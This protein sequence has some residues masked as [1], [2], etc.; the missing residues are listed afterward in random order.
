V[1]GRRIYAAASGECLVRD[2]AA[3]DEAERSRIEHDFYAGVRL[4]V[5]PDHEEVR[6][7]IPAK[8]RSDEA[9]FA[10][11][12]IGDTAAP[13]E[14]FRTVVEAEF[15]ERPGWSIRDDTPE[16]RLFQGLGRHDAN[17][18]PDVATVAERLPSEEPIRVGV[19]CR[20]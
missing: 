2:S 14:T 18:P 8:R 19:I 9:F 5:D 1:T 11:V 15:S 16:G 3:V 12:D 17:L 7:F 20:V 13:L 10:V 4:V 6:V